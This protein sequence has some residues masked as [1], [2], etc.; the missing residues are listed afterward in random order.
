MSANEERRSAMTWRQL[1]EKANK[2]DERQL[3][4]KVMWAGDERGGYVQYV[5]I[6]D[7]DQITITTV[8]MTTPDSELFAVTEEPTIVVE[9]VRAQ[10]RASWPA[11]GGER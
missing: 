8:D 9:M 5:E 10:F 7:E 1:K 11:P 3:D 4:M 2:L 6:I